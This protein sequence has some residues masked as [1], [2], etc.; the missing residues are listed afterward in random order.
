M[1]R[2]EVPPNGLARLVRCQCTC[3]HCE[4]PTDDKPSRKENGHEVF[5]LEGFEELPYERGTL[6]HH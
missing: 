4:D 3:G 5:V 6:V 2:V 1:R